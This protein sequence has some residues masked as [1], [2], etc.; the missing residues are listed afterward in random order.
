MVPSV[1]FHTLKTMLFRTQFL[2]AR[3]EG[4]VLQGSFNKIHWTGGRPSD[5]QWNLSW[6]LHT[7]LSEMDWENISIN[8]FLHT[9]DPQIYSVSREV[10]HIV[11]NKQ[12]GEKSQMDRSFVHGLITSLYGSLYNVTTAVR[13]PIIL[14][15]TKFRF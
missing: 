1:E 13:D 9:H 5:G 15:S 6:P 12:A 10:H 2:W 11:W 4:C 8:S 14:D 7:T 3:N